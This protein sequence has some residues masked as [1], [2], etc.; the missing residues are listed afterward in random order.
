[1]AP[2]ILSSSWPRLG[3]RYFEKLTTL[4]SIKTTKNIYTVID[5]I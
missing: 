4:T 3:L 2:E 1:M 5:E